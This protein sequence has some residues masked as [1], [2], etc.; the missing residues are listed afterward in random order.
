M[1]QDAVLKTLI[2]KEPLYSV[3]GDLELRAVVHCDPHSMLDVTQAYREASVALVYLKH[4]PFGEH[5]HM[6][7]SLLQNLDM[8]VEAGILKE[9]MTTPN[10]LNQVWQNHKGMCAIDTLRLHLKPHLAIGI[11]ICGS[12]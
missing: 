5:H 4:E 8:G 3:V 10:R 6:S 12:E 11:E 1:K 2:R 9:K 7:L